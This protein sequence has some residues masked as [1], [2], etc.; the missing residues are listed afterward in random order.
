MHMEMSEEEFEK[1]FKE[2]I[3]SAV[4]A[5]CTDES[6]LEILQKHGFK[7]ALPEELIDQIE[8]MLRQKPSER[9]SLLKARIPHNCN[10]CGVCSICGRWIVAQGSHSA[11]LLKILDDIGKKQ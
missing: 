6:M 2:L 9:R 3:N 7:M 11:T 10:W 8:P 5:E 1:F 4:A